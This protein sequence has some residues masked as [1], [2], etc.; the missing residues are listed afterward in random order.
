MVYHQ[1]VLYNDSSTLAALTKP[2]ILFEKKN[3]KILKLKKIKIK[4]NYYYCYCSSNEQ[5]QHWVTKPG[6]LLGGIFGNNFNI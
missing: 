1:R 5:L 4:I 6:N 2:I 3:V